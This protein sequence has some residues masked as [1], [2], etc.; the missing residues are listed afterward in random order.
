M[1]TL[2]VIINHNRKAYTNQLYRALKP[3][4]ESGNYYLTV[5][6][7]GTPDKEEFSE[8]TEYAVDT[9]TYYG[10]ALNL[11]F[12]LMLQSPEYDSVMVLNND[13]IVSPY[14]FVHSL[15]TT[16]FE[17]DYAVVAA[18]VL[19]PEEGQCTWKQMHNWG[20]TTPRDVKWVDF[21][22][23]LI[24]RKVVEHIKEYSMTLQY[25]W[26]Q[27]LYTGIV[28]E[29]LGWKLGVIDNM[30]LIHMSSQTY[31]DAKSDIPISEYA[32]RAHEGMY[33]FFIENN[34][35]EKFQEFKS[36]GEQYKLI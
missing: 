11:I 21:M 18:S 35:F 24:H 8:Y 32:R 19:Q 14:K 5:L 31:R 15:R 7:N 4:E 29:E 16:M 6:D 1:K 20:S 22:C 36:Y 34:K 9:N 12:G 2:C 27:D 25:G 10:G 28:C 33:R 30:T 26:G 3:Y 17:N 13:L 23:P